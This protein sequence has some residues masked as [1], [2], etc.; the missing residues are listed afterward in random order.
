MSEHLVFRCW[1]LEN[2]IFYSF[3][4]GR[5]ECRSHWCDKKRSNNE[6][7][8]ADIGHAVSFGE[9]VLQPQ[10]RQSNVHVVLTNGRL[11]VFIS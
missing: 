2:L 10:P 4:N 9:K 3:Q 7:K 11:I 1:V 6:F 5:I 8:D